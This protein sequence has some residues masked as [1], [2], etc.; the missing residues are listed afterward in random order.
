M[1]QLKVK[2]RVDILKGGDKLQSNSCSTIFADQTVSCPDLEQ[3][4]RR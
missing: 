1:T 3:I 4:L 2:E